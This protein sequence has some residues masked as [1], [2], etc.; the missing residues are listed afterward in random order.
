MG[1][2]ADIK[3][4]KFQAGG[5]AVN[6]CAQHAE[7]RPVVVEPLIGLGEMD[8][9]ARIPVVLVQGLLPLLDQAQVMRANACLVAV[10]LVE[11]GPTNGYRRTAQRPLAKRALFPGIRTDSVCGAPGGRGVGPVLPSRWLDFTSAER[12]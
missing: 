2:V 12:D 8:V 7:R 4:K 6:S 11:H 3:V 1:E 5:T 10:K 9:A